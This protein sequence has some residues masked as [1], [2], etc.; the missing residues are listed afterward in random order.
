MFVNNKKNIGVALTLVI[1]FIVF[2][3]LGTPSY[4]YRKDLEIR[5]FKVFESKSELGIGRLDTLSYA[6]ID[7][8]DIDLGF[9]NEEVWLGF[10]IT[11]FPYLEEEFNLEIKNPSFRKVD[12]YRIS[13]K[14]EIVLLEKAGNN[15][16]TINPFYYP[17]PVFQVLSDGDFSDN[18]ILNIRSTE[19]INFS[20]EIS[21]NYNFFSKYSNTLLFVS[22]Y[23]GIM[24]ALFL[25]NLILYFSI[26]DHVYIFYCFYIFFIAL[27]QLSLL[28]FSFYYILG[29]N[30]YLYEISIIGFST[31]SGVLGV[32]FVKHFLQTPLLAPFIDKVLTFTALVY[33]LAFG[34]RLLSFV[35]YSYL[36]TDIGGILVAIAFISAGI[37]TSRK[38]NRS[39][40]YFLIAWSV[41]LIGLIIYVLQN[42]G[43][44]EMETFANLPMLIGSAVESILLSLALADRINIL[45]KEKENEQREKVNALKENERLNK[46]QNIYLEKMVLLRTEEL[47]HTL[48]NLQNTQ[49]QLVNQEKM[50]SLGQLTAGIAHEINNP[51]N[52][53]SSN[54]S[55]LK[56][57]LKDILEVMD[58]YH[59]K[60]EEEFSTASK[61]EIS[62]LKEELEWG[63]LLKEVDQL[64]N[65]IEDGAKRTV[66]IVR[67]LRLFSRVDE[68]DIKK[69]N[70]HDGLDSTLI[71][72]NSSMQGSI[73]VI[74]EY[75][76]LPLVECLAGKI[77][78]VFMNIINN[79]IH[80]L[81]DPHHKMVNPQINIRTFHQE[82]H[83]RIEIQDN[84]PGMP[85]HV[86]EKIF[87]PFFTTKE[88]GKGT[89]LG[90]SIVYTVIENHK[91]RLEVDTKFKEG[92]IF[93]IILPVIQE[94]GKYE[95]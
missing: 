50:A 38:G 57:D 69:V 17:N 72:L 92:T 84:G 40:V 26:K 2:A 74:K 15:V 6:L 94:S 55:P 80:A 30:A 24:L 86:K 52:F 46:E 7:H 78:Q 56:R 5:N 70:I 62:D 95:G 10:D 66:E 91:G 13:K 12:L 39:A 44:I 31:C 83:I 41:F 53:V 60:G 4:Q 90:L 20:V 63:Y 34:F 51:I 89:G 87:E 42:H 3:N 47:E 76:E 36:L 19:P 11:G 18:F 23:V 21:S 81:L 65:G 85:D 82:D 67:G 29:Q 37:L 49:T 88:V 61:K 33:I 14:G 68:Q 16:G 54:I 48:K 71:L 27:A 59:Q 32:L 1:V 64:L 73:Q 9:V 8:P 58:V 79:A 45:K 25:Y 43:I 28:G 77:N 93:V 75:G 35:A 22:I